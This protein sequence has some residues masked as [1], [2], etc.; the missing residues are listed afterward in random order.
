MQAR[1][2]EP[3]HNRGGSFADRAA[4][5]AAARGLLAILA[6]DRGGGFQANVDGPAL[7]DI[8]FGGNSPRRRYGEG[9]A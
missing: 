1:P 5:D 9:R 2:L 7:V 4:A 6:Y 3:I 8:S